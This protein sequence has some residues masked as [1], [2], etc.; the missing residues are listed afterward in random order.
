MD[1][2][3]QQLLLTLRERLR[4][5]TTGEIRPILGF[6]SSEELTKILQNLRDQHLIDTISDVGVSCP[7]AVHKL[8]G[9]G[10]ETVKNIGR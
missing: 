1:W 7:N 8:T 5:V 2:K 4:G 6:L 3:A 9:L 10:L